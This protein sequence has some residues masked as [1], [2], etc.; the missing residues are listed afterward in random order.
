MAIHRVVVPYGKE[1]ELLYAGALAAALDLELVILTMSLSPASKA[2]KM[3]SFSVPDYP[4]ST[5]VRRI[6]DAS[7]RRPKQV[8]ILGY[9]GTHEHIVS[10]LQP[11]DLIVSNAHDRSIR[12]HAV[13]APQDE[14]ALFRQEKTGI[15]LPLGDNELATL[16][17]QYGLSLSKRLLP[18][19]GWVTL[20]H[21]T[22]K[23]PG[24]ADSSPADHISSKADTIVRLA[25]ST[26]KEL[27]MDIRTMIR[28]DETVVRG[29]AEAALRSN[30]S[31]IVV[32]RDPEVVLGDYS[33]QLAGLLAGSVP[34]LILP[35]HHSA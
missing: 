19:N 4:I 23:K 22:W 28:T 17:Y 5:D 32:V 3:E 16:T 25:E 20:Y 29:I 18:E 1:S 34:L 13:L 9:D 30:A 21:T 12:S 10:L 7:G 14:T 8:S 2:A 26:G 35:S 11:E 24:V 33:E 15:L 6:L 31:L 27:R